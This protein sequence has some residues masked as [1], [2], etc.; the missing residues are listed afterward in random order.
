M[1]ICIVSSDEKNSN[2]HIHNIYVYILLFI[3]CFI[4][5]SEFLDEKRTK[6]GLR[7][8]PLGRS[9]QNHI[10]NFRYVFLDRF[11][12]KYIQFSICNQ[13]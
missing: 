4:V 7:Y 5:Y 8:L 6:P 13:V 11:C 2:M 10:Q 1:I 9:F 12:I 3:Y